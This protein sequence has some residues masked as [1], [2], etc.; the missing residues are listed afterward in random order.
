MQ[1][2]ADCQVC[3][4]Q[5]KSW[6][7]GCQPCLRSIQELVALS[8]GG[9]LKIRCVERVIEWPKTNYSISWSFVADIKNT[10]FNSTSR[11]RILK[12]SWRIHQRKQPWLKQPRNTQAE[13]PSTGSAI[14]LTG[15]S[16]LSTAFFGCSWFSLLLGLQQHWL[17]TFGHNGEMN[18]WRGHQDITPQK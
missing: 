18:R 10:G 7:L 15:S 12:V 11:R 3:S 14:S 8:K 16:I 9:K 4:R 1:P 2:M 6:I 13:A 5:S 17:G